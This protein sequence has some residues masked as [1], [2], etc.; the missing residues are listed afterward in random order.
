MN[1]VNA[2]ENKEN[3]SLKKEFNSTMD[4]GLIF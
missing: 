4:A 1:M 3:R 2:Q